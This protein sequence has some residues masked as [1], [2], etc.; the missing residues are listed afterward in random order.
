[1]SDAG[2]GQLEVGAPVR[3]LGLVSQVAAI[4]VPSSAKVPVN[5]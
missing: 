5:R 1:M 3:P 4:V 2:V